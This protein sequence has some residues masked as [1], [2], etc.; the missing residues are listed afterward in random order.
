MHVVR[1]ALLLVAVAAVG[2]NRRQP[3]TAE[4]Q[5]AAPAPQ[6]APAAIGEPAGTEA[7][8]P[9]GA[10]RAYYWECEGGLKFVMKNLW[11]ENAVTLGLHEGS[12]RLERAPSA[13]GA[14]YADQSIEFWTKG[15]AGTLEHKPAAPMKCTEVR[16]RSL[17]EDARARG[18]AFRGRGNEPGWTVEIGPA[19]AIVLETNYGADRHAFASSSSSG[20]SSI[21]RTYTA[22]QDGHRVEVTVRRERCQD[23]MSGE[24]FDYS[25]R[26]TFGDLNLSGCGVNF[27]AGF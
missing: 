19:S 23:D 18:V 3:E 4:P 16:A 20:D 1:V 6:T 9:A 24:T 21:G 15:S 8:P 22:E 2:C 11:R 12:R 27:G 17:I 5:N 14:K 25:V 10:L 13:S 7:A 26:V